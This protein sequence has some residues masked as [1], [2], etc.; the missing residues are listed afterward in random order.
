MQYEARIKKP[1]M[2][3]PIPARTLM[4]CEAAYRRISHNNGPT[5]IR[6]LMFD[7]YKLSMTLVLTANLFNFAIIVP[8]STNSNKEFIQRTAIQYIYYNISI[9]PLY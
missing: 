9:K 6:W 1:E 2:S 7:V 3:C 5:M 4:V 8:F